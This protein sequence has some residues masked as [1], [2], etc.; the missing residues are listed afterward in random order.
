MNKNY[1]I[2]LLAVVLLIGTG[3]Y[4]LQTSPSAPE[5]NAPSASEEKYIEIVDGEE[6]ALDTPLTQSFSNAESNKNI[7]NTKQNT[8]TSS[9]LAQV[10]D[11]VTT[12]IIQPLVI[13][14]YYLDT[15][16]KNGFEACS[17]SGSQS[18]ESSEINEYISDEFEITSIE[19]SIDQVFVFIDAEKI[20][21]KTCAR[22]LQ[23]RDLT[24]AMYDHVHIFV[25]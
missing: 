6:V 9:V 16:Q 12:R 1:L 21:E 4:W 2:T 25:R 11:Q 17:Y 22:L 20:P 10:K 13:G 23:F 8:A 15:I 14:I 5:Y 19:K 3:I 24:T 7:I 18:T